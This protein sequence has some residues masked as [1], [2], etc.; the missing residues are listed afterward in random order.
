MF[1]C[2]GTYSARERKITLYD[3]RIKAMA[4]Q[5]KCKYSALEDAVLVHEVAHALIHLGIRKDFKIR[6]GPRLLKSP[7]RKN[8]GIGPYLH[9]QFAQI[10]A[11]K[12]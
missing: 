12:A 3:K 10:P 8:D 1:Y 7:D 9:E 4:R 11:Y 5:L 6:K 2:L